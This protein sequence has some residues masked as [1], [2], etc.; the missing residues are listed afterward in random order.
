MGINDRTS[1]VK[2]RDDIHAIELPEISA[3][4]GNPLT[5]KSWLYAKDSSGTTKLYFEDSA[6]T[7]T[8][9]LASS[10][11]AWDD[12][13]D[14]DANTSISMSTYTTT[15][16]SAGTAADMFTF[17]GT[18]NFA[19]VSI[20]KIE[21]KTGNP[22]D[23]TC[24]EVISADANVD[25][26]LVTSGGIAAIT[27]DGAGAVA[28]AGDAS[29]TGTFTAGTWAINA[30]AAA[31]ATTLT[32]DGGTTGGVNICSTST[33][34]ITLGDDVTVSSGKDLTLTDSQLVVTDTNNEDAVTINTSAT[35]GGS[36]IN[37][38]AGTT[39]DN[40][41]HVTADDLGAAGS[42][43]YLDSDN[44]AANNFYLKCYDGS[45]NDFTIAANG[46]T[47]ITG[48]AS[49]DMLTITAGHLQLTAGDIDV[50]NGMITVDTIQDISSYIKRNYAGAGTAAV[51]AVHDDH[52]SSTNYALSV[53]Q[54][55]TNGF[56]A[57]INPTV[58]TGDGIV[59]STPASYTGQLIKVE[60]T[61]VGTSGEGCVLD[62]KTTANLASGATMVRLDFD[63]GTMAGATDGF[64][65]SIDDDSV[66]VGTSYAVKIDSASNEALHVATG[67]ALFDEQPTFTGGINVDG[68]ID[69]DFSDNTE[70]ASIESTAVDRA[71]GDALVTIHGDHAGNTNDAALLRLVYQADGDAQDTFILCE[72][73]STG[74]AGNG[75]DM[76]KVGSG[77]A[78]TAAGLI[79]AAK[80]VTPGATAGSAA[81]LS[82]LN[83]ATV[84]LSNA[85]LKAL[86]GTPIALVASP[87]AGKFLELESV[88]FILN[89]TA[90]PFDAPDAAANLMV[91]YTASNV[92]AITAI[93]TSG[94]I[95][96]VADTVAIAKGIGLTTAL[97]NVVN[98]GLELYNQAAVEYT[99]S[100]DETATV[101]VKYWIHDDTV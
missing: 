14:P 84:S 46:A 97:S 19:D 5:D 26:L 81:S 7:V 12:V 1:K 52:A 30:V 53:T 58:A 40:V 75:D 36:A 43:I 13:G 41:I 90:D 95:D 85:N 35:T 72:D 92:A 2:L 87:G 68:I 77:G 66:G 23:G 82:V 93:E 34:G 91:Q 63:T 101:I 29:V 39:T 15:L 48:S 51:L 98:D 94:L 76:F 20:V 27:V 24:L 74:A 3:P 10:T 99:G 31:A 6:G 17:E 28:M 88:I 70:Y 59:F 65:L 78:V 49:T 61:L 71:A 67:K 83:V 56:C 100:A 16:T 80:G 57:F 25:A 8:D 9:L 79:S 11:T 21:Q 73:N 54:D 69:V 37:I 96:A 47:V 60:D 64:M 22:T 44:I 4:S 45:A 86:N 33:G 42:M 38:V 32:L 89:A 62:A 18:A 55:G 50:D